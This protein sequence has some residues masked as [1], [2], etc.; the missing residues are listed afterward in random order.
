M[1]S[2]SIL[3]CLF[4]ISVFVTGTRLRAQARLV[5]LTDYLNVALQKNP[6]LR[7][8]EQGKA[9]AVYSSES[10]R[11]GY[12][13]QFGIASHFI[14][15]PGYDQAVTNGGEV[16]AQIVGLYTLYDGGTRSY[17]I[18]KGGVGVEQGA[19]NINRTRADI[20]YSVSTAFA[21]AV[22][23]KRELD[24]AEQSY[25]QLKDYLQLVKQLHASGQG[26]ETDVLKTT[27]DLNNVAININARKVAFGNS[28]LVLAQASG[29]PSADVADVDSTV[30][31]TPFDTTFYADR[32]IDLASQELLLKQADLDAQIAGSKLRPTVSLGGDVGALTSLPNLQQGF[33]N[34]FGASVGLSFSLPF[35]TFGSLENGY[36][37]AKASAISISLQNDY[38]RTSLG[39]EFR[40]TRNG[41]ERANAEIAALQNNLV[42]AEQNLLL[43]K[44]RYA[45][46]SGLSLEVLDAIQMVNQIKLAIEEARSQLAMSVFK[47]NR[48]NYSGVAYK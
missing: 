26:S 21:A 33:S 39:H 28:L 20:V 34:V 14:V 24:V 22:K 40:I 38:A 12:L 44:A 41:V 19:L 1:K 35:L 23:E 25:A 37:A 43:S 10:V 9:S 31:S 48:L 29:L 6:L 45:G 16:S 2:K 7:A 13:P 3:A 11:K 27:V 32:N 5:S 36:N 18:Q 8:A 30:V 47:L 42:V 17:E 46:G 15:A 4:L